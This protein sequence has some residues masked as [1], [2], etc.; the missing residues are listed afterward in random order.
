MLT[1]QSQDL[2]I[3]ASL[4]V[5][6]QCSVLFTAH[7]NMCCAGNTWPQSNPCQSHAPWHCTW[8]RQQTCYLP[9][10]CFLKTS[11]FFY[12]LETKTKQ[13]KT[14]SL[15]NLP[16]PYGNS[17]KSSSVSYC[18]NVI[19]LE[20][21]KFGILGKEVTRLGRFISILSGYFPWAVEVH[22]KIRCNWREQVVLILSRSALALFTPF[23]YRQ[24][25]VPSRGLIK[26]T[27]LQTYSLHQVPSFLS[28]NYFSYLRRYTDISEAL[29]NRQ[30]FY[31]F[32][33]IS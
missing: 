26:K 11:V 31:S 20:C 30:W 28:F 10:W 3:W 5:S 19:Y 9:I 15:I 14:F 18:I 2:S 29:Q 17:E 21:C 6:V 32:V 27:F 8:A 13:N 23:L 16:E 25:N 1:G 12:I 7:F 22:Q 4:R 33:C 24:Q